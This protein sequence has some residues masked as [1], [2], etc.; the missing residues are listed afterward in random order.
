VSGNRRVPPTSRKGDRWAPTV[1]VKP[2][3]QA[4]MYAQTAPTT[5][6][7]GSHGPTFHGPP[8]RDCRVDKAQEWAESPPAAERG[9][10]GMRP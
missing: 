2:P 1:A 6:T 8:R 4:W 9:H 5:L 10:A 7:A 3:A